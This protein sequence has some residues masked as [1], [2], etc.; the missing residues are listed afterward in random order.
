MNY[1]FL[2]AV[3]YTSEILRTYSRCKADRDVPNG[4]QSYRNLCRSTIR[5]L[6]KV[7]KNS[8]N[9]MKNKIIKFRVSN[10]EQQIIYR[11]IEKSGLSISEFMRRLALD[12][13]IKN[14]LS[15][16]EISCYQALSKY[17]DNF[18]RI[19]NLFKFGD[20]TGMKKETLETAKAIRAHLEK[21]KK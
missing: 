7:A 15:E 3:I 13:D 2:S 19:S 10:L 1:F 9:H 6:P 17:S 4:P 12:L 16:D 18:R 11:K 5:L 8:K 21:F 14:R 20:V